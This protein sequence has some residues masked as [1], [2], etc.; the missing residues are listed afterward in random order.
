MACACTHLGRGPGLV[1]AID[2]SRA[3]REPTFHLL[4]FVSC[5]INPSKNVYAFTSS[6]WSRWV[7]GTTCLHNVWIG[8]ICLSRRSRWIQNSKW[9]FVSRLKRRTN[10]IHVYQSDN[11][12]SAKNKTFNTIL[13]LKWNQVKERFTLIKSLFKFD[14]SNQYFLP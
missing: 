2:G 13:M 3:S 10:L 8:P 11:W 1:W 9:K 5:C 12:M 14:S 4:S 6:R 7:N